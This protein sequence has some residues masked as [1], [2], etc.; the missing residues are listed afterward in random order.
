M[1]DETAPPAVDDDIR[2]RVL[3]SVIKGLDWYAE[4]QNVDGSWSASV[5]VTGFIVICFTGAGYDHTNGTV[6]RALGHLR[7]FYNDD[8]GILADTFPN[9]ETAI[10]LIAMA[11]AGDPEDADKL[12]K[13][14]G[15]LRQLQFS[16][17]SEYNK[18]EPWYQ[19]GWPN[20]AG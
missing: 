11:G 4:T 7:N 17:D 15:Y 13:M 16:D 10:S 18:T 5:G 6:Q 19:G 12:E 8:T 2:Q 14:A 1:A 9:Y 3:D 20:Y